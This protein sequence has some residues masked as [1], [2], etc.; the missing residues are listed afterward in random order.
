MFRFPNTFAR[1]SNLDGDEVTYAGAP[2]L[3]REL[4][5]IGRQ[6]WYWHLR[7]ETGVGIERSE[8]QAI[9]LGLASFLTDP[10][11]VEALVALGNEAM[12]RLEEI[13][14]GGEPSESSSLRAQY[15]WLRDYGYFQV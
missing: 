6:V 5:S 15:D 12:G 14:V 1:I 11:N 3:Y 10:R 8:M 13:K 9:A 2:I 7:Y 4:D